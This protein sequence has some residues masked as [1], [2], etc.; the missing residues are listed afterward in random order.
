MYVLSGILVASAG[1]TSSLRVSENTALHINEAGR[2]Y[3][4]L[5]AVWLRLR[6][7]G[8]RHGAWIAGRAWT[9]VPGRLPIMIKIHVAS[10]RA[11]RRVGRCPSGISRCDSIESRVGEVPPH[12]IRSSTMNQIVVNRV[13]FILYIHS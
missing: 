8:L 7:R 2:G 1:R 6:T 12:G 11:A 13:V 5:L 10:V 4:S 9:T 3:R